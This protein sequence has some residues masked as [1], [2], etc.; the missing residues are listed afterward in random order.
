MQRT[1]LIDA[2]SAVQA[3]VGFTSHTWIGTVDVPAAVVVTRH[4]R[5]VP[6]RR[7][8]KLALALPSS[9]VVEIDGGHDVFLEAPGRLAAAVEAA[10]AAVCG[11]TGEG[12]VG[13]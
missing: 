5:V 3:V 1:T 9:T 11:G 12:A 13:A 7:Q 2:L 4:D 6:A 10:C 8:H